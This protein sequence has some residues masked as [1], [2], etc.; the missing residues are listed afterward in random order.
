MSKWEVLSLPVPSWWTGAA[1]KW[2]GGADVKCQRW[3]LP[4][5]LGPLLCVP[6]A[7]SQVDQTVPQALK[8]PQAK[9][10]SKDDIQS[11][12]NR[13][14]GGSGMGNW[15][16]LEHEI[17]IGRDYSRE[18]E[19]SV[20]LIQDPAVT[21]Y[22]N[23]IGQN[24]V[25]NSD[26]KVPF[27]IK[28]IDSEEV[29]AFA[30]PGGFLYVNSGL[31]LAAENEAE[32]AG[33]MAHEIAHVAARHAT[34]Q[35]TRSQMFNLA[36]IPLI[37]VGGG[38]GVAVQQAA[39][40]AIPLSLT[41]FSRGF[42]AEADYLGVEY[43]HKAGYDP[44]AFISFFERVQAQEKQKPGFIAKAFSDHPQTA[45]RMK[46][47]QREIAAILPAREAYVISTSEFE[48]VKSRLT[49]IENGHRTVDQDAERPT[50]RR[51]TADGNDSEDGGRPTLKR[52]GD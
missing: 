26:A 5:V 50:L 11:I 47:A 31:V 24:L 15:Y 52:R 23:R 43:L 1:G 9:P 49:S 48:E 35:M 18:I 12:G 19:G 34:R 46:K 42:E 20:K 32:L 51:R 44:Q 14:I 8:V 30:L 13:K 4:L 3:I 33:V 21:E 6:V 29:N 7:V 22:V 37:F 16:S 25:R 38:I 40:L 39:G 10:G 17:S 28:V 2:C 45:D 41:K 27:T 36:S